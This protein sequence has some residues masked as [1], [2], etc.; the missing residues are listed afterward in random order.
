MFSVV[1]TQS[2][3]SQLLTLAWLASDTART[4]DPNWPK[5]YSIP[6]DIMLSI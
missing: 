5:G 4:A 3:T 2:R 6:Y 1:A